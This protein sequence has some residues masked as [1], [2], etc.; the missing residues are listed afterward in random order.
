M[1]ILPCK[2]F[3]PIHAKS[4][5]QIY[6]AQI[7]VNSSMSILL[8]QPSFGSLSFWLILF[9][10]YLNHFIRVVCY[11]TVPWR[12]PQ[13]YNGCRDLVPSDAGPEYS[14]P[15]WISWP[16]RVYSGTRFWFVP[17]RG[18]ASSPVPV[19]SVLLGID[20]CRILLSVSAAVHWKT[21]FWVSYRPGVIFLSFWFFSIWVLFWK[22]RFLVNVCILSNFK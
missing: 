9:F 5:K 3:Q 12:H 16:W 13:Q 14:Y 19:S 6:F 7:T 11:I 2:K 10:Q 20:T 15:R 4:R 8:S 21:Q 18:S 1:N 17:L 22:E